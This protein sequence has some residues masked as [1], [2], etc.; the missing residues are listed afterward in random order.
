[1]Q[2]TIDCEYFEPKK[3]EVKLEKTRYYV[4]FQC[5]LYNIFKE[6]LNVYFAPENMKKLPSKVALNRPKTFF[7]SPGLPAQMAQKQKSRTTKSP[8]MQDWV[9]RLGPRQCLNIFCWLGKVEISQLEQ[10]LTLKIY[11]L[12]LSGIF[13]NYVK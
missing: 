9:F 2:D 4:T 12:G 10:H 13:R 3:I 1:M 11:N 5:R 8:L 6:I 7:F